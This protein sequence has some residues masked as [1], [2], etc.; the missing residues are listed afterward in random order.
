MDLICELIKIPSVSG[1]IDGI[2]KCMNICKNYVKAVPNVIIKEVIYNNIP[3]M[4]ISN[5]DTLALDLLSLGH[6]DVVES[7]N[8]EMF[9]PI[10]KGNK[11]FGRGSMDMKSFTV[12]YLKVFK[13]LVLENIKLKFGILIVGDE[14][15]GGLNGSKYWSEE[16][17][18]TTKI[19]LDCDAGKNIDTIVQNVKGAI[20][21]K[22]KCFGINCHGSMPWLGNDAN[23]NLINIINNLRNIFPY[24]NIDKI[25]DNKFITTMHIGIINGGKFNNQI[26]DY[27]ECLINIRYND[28]YNRQDILNI[29]NNNLINNSTIEIVA[30][31]K[32]INNDVNNNVLKLYEKCITAVIKQPV[33]FINENSSSDARYFANNNTIIISHQATGD[34]LH[35]NEEWVDIITLEQLEEIQTNFIRLL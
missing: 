28:E 8:L 17:K 6:L 35:S 7:T 10:I 24:Y 34:G 18:L 23:Q 16:L 13:K 9:N 3:S 33:K 11:L 14:E 27:A 2:N 22:L 19:L 1:N 29:I 5:A 4:L 25:P 15:T 30:E 20:L 26:S 21:F 12:I 31:G 32:A